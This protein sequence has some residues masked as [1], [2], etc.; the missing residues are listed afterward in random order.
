MTVKIGTIGDRIANRLS[1]AFPGPTSEIAPARPIVSFSFDDAPRSAWRDGA[2]ILE[3]A[4]GRGTYYLAGDLILNHARE[5]DLTPA[6]GCV[7][8]AAR[9]HELGC[10]TFS[11]VKLATMSREALAADLDRNERFLRELDGRTARR[12]FAVPYTMMSP[13]RQALLRSRFRSSRS[14]WPAVNRGMTNLQG[15]GAVELRQSLFDPGAIGAWLDDLARRPGWLIFFTHH[16]RENPPGDY[17]LSPLNFEAA[18]NAVKARG[19]DILTVD[20]ALD[21]IGIAR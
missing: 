4:G 16:V 17:G 18:V 2:A 11:H 9:G 21:R 7:D 3:A 8:L 5:L 1:R 14:G 10:H 13:G 6:E 20:A 19:F 12:N 15:L